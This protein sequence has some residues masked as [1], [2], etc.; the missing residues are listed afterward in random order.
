MTGDLHS[1]TTAGPVPEAEPVT[2]I[3]PSPSAAGDDKLAKAREVA[4]RPEAQVG[5]AFA[6][7][8]IAA[9]ILKRLT[10]G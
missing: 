6:G 4:Q 8:V 9:M 5:A 1:P 2:T 10:R 3:P 7:G